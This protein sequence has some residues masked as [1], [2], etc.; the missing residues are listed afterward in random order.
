MFQDT[1]FD[2]PFLPFENSKAVIYLVRNP[3][4]LAISF[5]RHLGI[6]ID[7]TIDIMNQE[8]YSLSV[9]KKKYLNQV[10][11]KIGSWSKHVESWLTQ[12]KIPLI[13]VKYEDMLHHPRETFEKML[14]FIDVNY[15]YKKL[16]DALH[17]ASFENLA[18]QEQLYGFEEK[19]PY[20]K[21]FFHTGKSG[22][23]KSILNINQINTIFENHK[24][25]IKY[26]NYEP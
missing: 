12:K 2:M 5:S 10:P 25:M 15:S 18:K 11:Q 13:L 6:S 23:Y 8:N 4:D 1:L 3:F 19:S 17:F 22:Y 9:P 20:Q 26:L 7:K 24:S 21:T 16:D 14:T